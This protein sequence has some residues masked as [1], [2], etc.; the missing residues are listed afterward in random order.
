MEIWF[1][2]KPIIAKLAN[3][4]T[5]SYIEKIKFKWKLKKIK[6]FRSNFENSFVDSY[7]FQNFLNKEESGLLI[8]EYVFGAT[9][10]PIEQKD[11]IVQLSNLAMNDINENRKIAGLREI[12]TEP[13]V[14]RYFEDLLNYLI[15]FRNQNFKSN[16]QSMIANIQSSI[17][18]NSVDIKEHLDENLLEIQEKAHLKVFTEEKIEKL[19]ERSIFDLG[20]RYISD[21]NVETDMNII[22]EALASE[23]KL[24]DEVA[25]KV[26]VLS[27]K[28]RSLDRVLIEEKIFQKYFES[29]KP[30]VIIKYL[31]QLEFNDENF[32]QEEKLQDFINKINDYTKCLVEI[33]HALTRDEINLEANKRIQITSLM[34]DIHMFSKS[35]YDF[36]ESFVPALINTPYL[37]I[38]GDGGIGKSHLLAD[39]AVKLNKSGHIVFLILGQHLNSQEPPFKQIFSLL[40]FKGST[41]SF[42]KE[43]DRRAKAINKKTIIMIDALN[44]GSGKLFWKNYLLNFLNIVKEF[45]NISIVITVRSNFMRSVI[46]DNIY[47]D[48]PLTSIE[49]RGFIDSNLETLEP[50]FHHYKV[51]PVIFP[52]LESECYNP[53]FLQIYCEVMHD[54]YK[55]YKGWSIVEV[56]EKYTSKINNRLSI[57]QRF[58]YPSSINIVDRILKEIAKESLMNKSQT[59]GIDHL[60]KILKEVAEPY[61]IGYREIASGLEEENLLTINRYDGKEIVYFTYERFSDIYI[62]DL[63]IDKYFRDNR[64]FEDLLS[65]EDPFYIAIYEALSILIPEKV[66]KEFLDTIDGGSINYYIADA[67]IRG[68]SWRNVKNMDAKTLEWIEFCLDKNTDLNNLVYERLLKQSYIGESPIN[69]RFLNKYLRSMEMPVRDSDWSMFVNENTSIPNQLIDIIMADSLSFKHLKSENRELIAISIGWF[70]TSTNREIRD[71]A[72][73]ALVKVYISDPSIIL[74]NLKVFID[75]DDPY[76]LERVLAS[77]YGAILRIGKTPHLDKIAKEIYI[78][79]FQRSEVYPNILVRDYSRSIILFLVEKEMITS[80][81]YKNIYPPYSSS[82]YEK[83]FSLEDIEDR[84]RILEKKEG[85]NSGGFNIIVNSMITEYGRGTGGYGDFGRYVFGAVLREWKNQFDDQSLSNIAVM[86]IIDYGYDEVLHGEYDTD[87]K[88]YGWRSNNT[89]RI[90]KKYQWI[91]L[92]ELVA[93]LKD[94]YPV[95]E[96]V[97]IYSDEYQKFQADRSE[98]LLEMLSQPGSDGGRINNFEKDL[99][100]EDHLIEINKSYKDSYEESCYP[101]LRNIDPSLLNYPPKSTDSLHTHNLPKKPSIEWAQNKK[102]FEKLN[103]FISYKFDGQDYI[104][105][106]QLLIQEKRNG[107]KFVDKDE[108]VVKTKAISVSKVDKEKYIEIKSTRKN[109]LS[110]EWPSNYNLFAFEYYWHP[111]FETVNYSDNYDSVEYEE[112]TWDY[113]WESNIEYASKERTSCSYLL[114]SSNL[115][116]YFNLKQTREG[117]WEN[118][119]GVV[120]ALDTQYLGFE[121]NLLFKKEYLEEYLLDSEMEIVWDF[122]M[123]KRSSRSRKEEWFVTWLDEEGETQYEILDEYI[124]LQMEDRF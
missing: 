57:D 37:L 55:D 14:S 35:L 114:P 17:L 115:V 34:N 69:A 101:L 85:I 68:L 49:H 47:D 100:A 93:K 26:T 32:Y 78:R 88:Q 106:G 46:P 52:S 36:I 38:H 89:E 43:F 65:S 8:F 95:F 123:E 99:K 98:R 11:F 84:R 122:Y 19:L 94:N 109:N 113:V 27:S 60:Y 75:V 118:E 73:H 59:I 33:R 63:L 3:H 10:V 81:E 56:L 121:R 108:F 44:E 112:M 39:N 77:T 64:F 107:E 67:F 22:F 110:V 120:V 117:K 29:V 71:T 51:N 23:E 18:E 102:E 66:N 7:T 97:K 82:W 31:E 79:I 21:A 90:G 20:K 86:R 42:L 4:I 50:F 92:Y 103:K 54:E 76:V 119:K 48:F 28:I 1:L 74:K 96:E 53:L 41:E 13:D 40:D 16:E 124:D 70:F 6:D 2:V 15:D 12:E 83:E 30:E 9:F 62:A 91:A 87:L 61:T 25:S 105:L 58:S 80:N 116:K 45:K 24:F 104:S 72:T 111:S 5:G